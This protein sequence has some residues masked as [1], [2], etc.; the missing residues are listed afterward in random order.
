MKTTQIAAVVACLLAAGA[1][2]ASQQGKVLVLDK[3][4]GPPGGTNDKS[5]GLYYDLDQ[6]YA[7][8]YRA[9]RWSAVSEQTGGGVTYFVSADGGSDAN[10]CAG[11]GTPCATIQGAVMKIPT[12]VCHNVNIDV[13]VGEYPPVVMDGF[14]QCSHLNSVIN[15]Y[16]TPIT[17]TLGSGAATGDV[18]SADPGGGWDGGWMIADG[19]WSDDSLV[20]KFLAIDGDPDGYP[21][22]GNNASQVWVAGYWGVNSGTTFTIKEPGT[23]IDAGAGTGYGAYITAGGAWIDIAFAGSNAGVYVNTPNRVQFVNDTFRVDPAYNNLLYSEFNT[24]ISLYR[25]L[26]NPAGYSS[27]YIE[28]TSKGYLSVTNTAFLGNGAA[29]YNLGAVKTNVYN[30]FAHTTAGSDVFSF[31]GAPK[32]ANVIGVAV[33]CSTTPPYRAFSADQPGNVVTLDWVSSQDCYANYAP[34][35]GS[36]FHL[37]RHDMADCLTHFTPFGPSSARISYCG[38]ANPNSTSCDGTTLYIDGQYHYFWEVYDAGYILI[39]ADLSVARIE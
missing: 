31:G 1:L 36:T 20:G 29:V 21:I 27:I 17:S 10:D 34:S 30:S 39:G 3:R 32:Q 22:I 25:D 37:C 26:F 33:V 18:V 7:Q 4:H 15:V 8:T 11:W 38:Y 28:D 14:N 6:N 13:D 35:N 24:N 23:V 16:G 19:G 2:A 5:G 12:N 9:G